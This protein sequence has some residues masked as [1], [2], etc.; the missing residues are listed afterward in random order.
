MPTERQ[1]FF[2]QQGYCCCRSVLSTSALKGAA[3]KAHA[4]FIQSTGRV[5]RDSSGQVVKVSDLLQR[6]PLFLDVLRTPSILAVLK[7]ML[8]E[9]IVVLLNRHNHAT[10]NRAGSL[11]RLHRD[12]IHWSRSVLTMILYLEPSTI[13]NGCTVLIPGSHLLPCDGKINNGG[14]WLDTSPNFSSLIEQALPVPVPAGGMLLFESLVYHSVGLNTAP[15]TRMSLAFGLR[16]VDELS[17][18]PENTSQ[19]LLVCG[20]WQYKGNDRI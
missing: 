1:R 6:D 3:D 18:G 14:T 12:I 16:A 10:L 19:A 20:D 8:G 11:P 15:D 9:N 17:G 4:L 5:E 7:E 2:R 13:Q